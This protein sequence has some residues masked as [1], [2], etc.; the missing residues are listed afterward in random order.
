M[1]TDN[2]ANKAT[3]QSSAGIFRQSGQRST[4][5]SIGTKTL[6]ILIALS[7]IVTFP[8]ATSL[9]AEEHLSPG[10][11][12]AEQPN[13]E[14]ATGNS[15]IVQNSEIEKGSQKAATSNPADE[16]HEAKKTPRAVLPVPNE[17]GV[18]T[19]ANWADLRQAMG[20][21]SVKEIRFNNTIQR[22]GGAGSG[23]DLPAINRSLVIDAQGYT[24]DWRNDETTNGINRAGFTLN[25]PSGGSAVF[26]LKN[27]TV[28]RSIATSAHMIQASDASSEN[29]TVN[30]ENLST[31]DTPATTSGLLS[32]SRATAI[33]FS[34]GITWNSGSCNSGIVVAPIQNY[35]GAN[36]VVSITG[37]DDVIRANMNGR[38][39]VVK[40]A[41]GAD[42]FLSGLGTGTTS[43]VD[44]TANQS[45]GTKAEFIVDGESTIL[46]IQ[47]T[48]SGTGV[49]GG[50]VTMAAAPASSGGGGGF[51]VTGGATM[52]VISKRG[53]PPSTENNSG[54]PAL[55]Q[56]IDGGNF[57]VDGEGTQLNV[58]SY[59]AANNLGAT[60]RIREVG[61]QTFTLSNKAQLKVIK[62][63][64]N[65]S[66]S[67][68][69]LRFGTGENNSFFVTGGASVS[70]FNYGNKRSPATS[71]SPESKGA[72]E[73][74]AH[75]FSFQVE[76][77]QSNIN[78]I[79]TEGAAVG[80]A[81]Y[82]RG[83]ISVGKGSVFIAQGNVDSDTNGVFAAGNN[84]SFDCN[85]PLYYNFANANGRI[86]SRVFSIAG[87]DNTFSSTFSDLAVWGN[88]RARVGSGDNP[89]GNATNSS[90]NPIAGSPY[91]SWTLA[92]YSL[93]GEHF[94]TSFVSSHAL[95][96]NKVDSFGSRGM[97]PYWRIS[98][99]NAGPVI[100]ELLPATNADKYVR[101]TGTV[102]EGLDFY[103]RPFWDDEIFG[104]FNIT[105]ADGSTE[106]SGKGQTKSFEAENVYEVESVATPISS[107]LR[108]GNGS[109][110][111]TGEKY[112][113][114]S[115]WRGEVD[116]HDLSQ[117][118]SAK[119]EDIV[120]TEITVVDVLPP[121][122]ASITYPSNGRL[123]A[124]LSTQVTGTW[125]DGAHQ[126]LAQPHNPE[127]A[128][129]LYAVVNS[130][131]N[132]ISENGNPVLGT[133]NAD[134]TWSYLITEEIVNSLAEKDKVFFVLED[135]NGN[136]NPIVNTSIR[137]TTKVAAPHLAVTTSDLFLSHTDAFI[138]LNK[139]RELA[140]LGTSSS[141]QH[142]AFLELLD[143]KAEKRDPSVTMN[144]T[145]A[146]ESVSPFWD[147]AGY[148]D[149]T[150]FEAANPNGKSYAVK[151]VATEDASLNN[152]G[153]ITVLPFGHATPYIGA[154]DFTISRNFATNMMNTPT[155][156]R[157]NQLVDL[158]GA[159]GRLNTS[160]P[161]SKNN[162]VVTS[163]A[164]P[165][166][167]E[168]GI[169]DVTFQVKGAPAT[170]EYSITVKAHIVNGDDPVLMVS[171]PI[172][173]W[174]GDPAAKPSTAILPDEFDYRMGVTAFSALNG[175]NI[176]GDV[177]YDGAVNETKKGMYLVRYSVTNGDFNS[178][179]ATRVVVVNDGSYV[180]VPGT[181]ADP[182][183]ILHAQSFVK[184]RPDTHY[185]DI[186]TDSKAQA[187]IVD[188][189][190]SSGLQD[191]TA[192]VNSSGSY[193][194]ACAVGEYPI[195]IRAK[196]NPAII[197]NITAKVIEKNEI[198]DG[199][200][201]QTNARY[202]IGANDYAVSV[203]QVAEFVGTS[204][205]VALKLINAS[206]AEAW[207]LAGNITPLG[208]DLPLTSFGDSGVY[209][210]SNG[211]PA[212]GAQA[213]DTYKI[214]FAVKE[215]PSIQ[216]TVAYTI[217]GTPP[218][219]SYEPDGYPL[220]VKQSS[221]PH[222]MTDDEVKAKMTVWDAQD[223]NLLNAT[224]YV[225]DNT[226]G[227]T[228]DT[229]VVG[230]Y[231]VSY[232]VT[233][234]DGMSATA[235]RAIIVDDG[236][237][238]IDQA[239]GVIIGAKNFVI[240]KKEV[241]G[242][243]DQVRSYSRAYA[244]TIE[245]IS[246]PSSQLYI[247]NFPPNNYGA[248]CDVGTYPF[249]WMVMNKTTEK[250]IKGYV[251]DADII[252]PGG[253]NGQYAMTAR[254]FTVN[255]RE[256]QDMIDRGLNAALVS[257]ADVQVIKLV[258]SVADAVPYVVSNGG[259]SATLNT[260]P[261]YPLLFGA[262]NGSPLITSPA[263]QVATNGKVSQGSEP[264]LD[265]PT[266]LEVWIGN[267]ANKPAGAITPSEY[268]A[269]ANDQYGV[270]ALDDED[271]DITSKVTAVSDS[272]TGP[273]NLSKVGM[274]KLAYSV[275]DSDNNEVSAS[276]IVVVNDGN[277]TVGKG[278][279][280]FA[281]SFVTLLNDVTSDVSALEAEIL[282]K[283][284]VRLY[285]GSTGAQIGLTGNIAGILAGG[286][287]KAV[288]VY[289]IQITAVDVPSGT[290]TKPII[291][292]VVDAGVIGPV[293]PPLLDPTVYV[294]GNHLT[295]TISEA[296]ALAAA[297]ET[298]VLN[299][300]KTGSTKTH[301]DGTIQKLK[302]IIATD[303][304]AFLAKLTDNNDANDVGLFTMQIGD[305]ENTTFITLT[306][307]VTNGEPP[308]LTA[309][310]KPLEYLMPVGSG[311]LDA[312]GNLTRDALMAG[313]VATDADE[314]Q[315]GKPL[316]DVRSDV[317]ISILN[318]S[319]GAPGVGVSAIP[320]NQ[321]G[322]YRVTYTYVDPDRNVALDS[323]AII[324]NDGRYTYDTNFI[325]E[326]L[327]F[328]IKASE[329]DITNQDPQLLAK[330]EAAIWTVDG[331]TRT[332]V[333][334]SNGG[335]TATPGIDFG[336]VIQPYGYTALE[337]QIAAKVLSD[338]IPNA[339][340]P[341]DQNGEN[342]LARSIV[343]NN[344]RINTTDANALVAQAGTVEYEDEFLSRANVK[345][346]D[347]T[348]QT[349]AESPSATKLLVDDDGFSLA[350]NQPLKHGDSFKITH[351]CGG[352]ADAK[353]TIIAFV[354]NALPPMISAPAVRVVWTGDPAKKPADAINLADWN[355]MNS[356]YAYDDY[357]GNITDKVKLGLSQ[358]GSFVEGNPV[359]TNRLD[360]FQPISYTVTD[361]D[362]N[363]TEKTVHVIV[364]NKVALEG[365]Y[366]ILAHDFM[367]TV[368]NVSM[369]G[370]SDQTVLGLSAAKAWRIKT[371]N[372]QE[373]SSLPL[374]VNH[375][376][377][378]VDKAGYKAQAGTYKPI[379]IGIT[380]ELLYSGNP[381]SSIA[382]TVIERDEIDDVF[383]DDVRYYV[384]ANH[385]KLKLSEAS[386]F[387]GLSDSVKALLVDRAKACGWK[388]TDTTNS[389]DVDVISN[390]I[391]DASNPVIAGGKYQVTFIPK[392]VPGA[393]VSVVFEIDDG[394]SPV[395]LFEENPLVLKQS[396]SSYLLSD[397]E[398]K[399]KMKVTDLEDGDL[400]G[401]TSI[402]LP[403]GMTAIDQ[404]KIDVYSI[405]YN[406]V[407]SQGNTASATRA[408]VVDDGRFII[409]ENEEI[410]IGARDYVVQS[411][412]VTGTEL[413]AKGLSFAEAF[414]FNGKALEVS[415]SGAPQGYVL[416]AKVGTYD[417][418]WMVSGYKIKKQIKAH[419]T[420]AEVID[421][422]NKDDQHA[423]IASS[424]KVN[425]EGAQ[426][427]L[428]NAPQG[429]VDTAKAQ[430]IKLVSS[431]ADASVALKNTSGF[432]AVVA[433][434]PITFGI[435]GTSRSVDIVGTVSQGGLPDLEVI[436]PLEVWIGDVTN[437][438]AN[439][440]LP[441]EYHDLF[442]VD[443]QDDEEGDITNKVVVVSGAGTVDL[444]SVGLYNLRYSVTDQDKNTV[445]AER[446]VV[447]NDGRFDVGDGRILFAKPFVTR[448]AD[449]T[450][451]S[452]NINQEI[453]NKSL[454]T[455]FHGVSGLELNSPK[456]SV[457]NSGGYKAAIG[458]YPIT[459]VGADEPSGTLA[460][461]ITGEVVD[462]S[463][464]E[465]GPDD[466]FKDTYYL[467][468]NN[469]TIT[470]SEARDI[471]N[472]ANF[473]KALLDVLGAGGLKTC[474]DGNLQSFEPIIVDTDSFK[475]E[476]GIYK[477]ILKD[478]QNNVSMQLTVTVISGS[479]PTITAIPTP[480]EY[481]ADPQ[482]SA[483]LSRDE[484]MAGVA[485]IDEDETP[486]DISSWVVINPDSKGNE[487]LPKI[488]INEASVTKVTYFVQD[489]DGNMATVDRAII[490]ND[491]SISFNEKYILKANSFVLST[492][493][494]VGSSS[495]LILTHSK[496]KAWDSAGNP[497]NPVVND[498]GMFSLVPGD[499]YPNIGVQEDITLSKTITARVLGENTE[500]G[501]G[502]RH[503]IVADNFRIS[504]KDAQA[505]QGKKGTSEYEQIFLDRAKVASFMNT[506]SAL[507]S[508]G[509][510]RLAS[511]GGFDTAVFAQEN[512]SNYPSTFTVKFWVDE[513]K[514]AFCEIV[515]TVSNGN[516]PWIKAPALKQVNK[517]GIFTKEDYL[518][519]VTYGDVE[520]DI[521][522]LT[523][524]HNEPVDTAV[525]GSY[526]VVYTVED[527][528]GNSATAI[529][530]V[531][532]GDW[533]IDGDYAVSASS[534]VTTV[535]VAASA[536]SKDD[537]ILKLS[538]GKALGVVRDINGN[539]VDIVSV[540][541][542]VKSSAAFAAAV[543]N[544]APIKIGIAAAA[545]P[546]QSI[547][548][549][550]IDKDIIS[551]IPDGTGEIPDVNTADPN[552]DNR[553]IVAGNK[554]MLSWLDAGDLAGK[555]D[556]KTKTKLI[557]LAQAE[558]FKITGTSDISGY[559]VDV[560]EN[561]IQQQG[562][563]YS[564][565]F[566][567]KGIGGVSIKVP[568]EVLENVMPVL[569]VDGPLIFKQ[570]P[571]SVELM[572]DQL[573]D[574]VSVFDADDA[575][576]SL[577][578]VVIT[579]ANNTMPKIDTSKVGIYQVT[580]TVADKIIVDASGNPA[581]V[582]VKR[583]VIVDDGR[584]VIDSKTE[585][586]VE[587]KN[588]VVSKNHNTF[589]GSADDV[590]NRSFAKAW[591][592]SGNPLKVEL[593]GS[594]PPGFVAKDLGVYD[595]ALRAVGYGT[596]LKTIQGEVVDADVVIPGDY[597][598]KYA[599]I[600]SHFEV[601]VSEA[602]KIIDDTGLI[603]AASARVIKLLP[604]ISDAAVVVLD[605]GGFN[606][607]KGIY[608]ILFGIEGASPAKYTAKINGV[609]SDETDPIL[610]VT[611]PLELQVGDSWNRNTAMR[612]VSAFDEG[613][614]NLTDKVTYGP[615][616]GSSYFED[617]QGNL[618]EV[619]TGK[620][621]I[622]KLL[623]E[624]SDS[625]GNTA[626]APRVVVVNDGRY[627]VGSGRIL[628][629]QPFVI[630]VD[631]VETNSVELKNHL[632]AMT[633]AAA[634]DGTTGDKLPSREIELQ[635]SGNYQPTAGKYNITL[636]LK[637]T[638]TGKL[639]K[640][641][642]ALVVDAD[643]IGTKP[644]D[645]KDPSGSQV[646]IYGNNIKLRIS[647]AEK[648]LDAA[649]LE[650]AL[651][652]A[653]KAG[654]VMG[655][656][657]NG[658][659]LNQ[660][661]KITNFDDFAAVV[662]VYTITVTDA[663]GTCSIN[664]TVTVTSG[665]P[666]TITAESPVV[667]PLSSAGGLLS[668]DQKK[669]SAKASD[670]EDGDLTKEIIA[671]GLVPANV[672]GVYQVTLKVSD[673]DGNIDTKKIAVVVDDGSFIYGDDTILTA[674]SFTLDK[675]EVDMSNPDSQ[676]LLLSRAKAYKKDGTPTAV[677]VKD[678]A[679]YRDSAGQYRPWIMVSVEPGLTK[680]ITATVT[681]P[682]V[683]PAPPAPPVQ[684]PIIVNPP[685][686]NIVV[687]PPASNTYVKVDTLPAPA[688]E[689]APQAE[690]RER[691]G[692]EIVRVNVPL[693]SIEVQGSWALLNLCIAVLA[694]LLLL[695]FA[696]RFFFDRRDLRDYKEE[697]IDQEEW[698]KMTPAQR[699]ALVVRR[700][701]ERQAFCALQQ[702]NM[703]EKSFYVNAL[704]LAIVALAFIEGLIILIATQDFF[705]KMVMTDEFTVPLSLVVMVQLIV[706]MV[707][708]I[709]KNRTENNK[710]LT[711]A[712]ESN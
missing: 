10:E 501:N 570:T 358:G 655:D 71:G 137:D 320:A 29:W 397:D 204:D 365:D 400:L 684:P 652:F 511:D 403:S 562:G 67:P 547:A 543:G 78:I 292:E 580:Y 74:A 215:A 509:T 172:E 282:S 552:D 330:S 366:L 287:Q 175:S 555:L 338:G 224:K 594:L 462:A 448:L 449:V 524:T 114:V 19:V 412:K 322:I 527:T 476:K 329:V 626:E 129:K 180:V 473:N 672:A 30:I 388:V 257:R 625:D 54:M 141:Q 248:G 703:K 599:L 100:R 76:D 155:A 343:E 410:I 439:A 676:I 567:P 673:S 416:E 50:T 48:G 569:I 683:P 235:T 442:G 58:E 391:G 1:K 169:Y 585:A 94:G 630:S 33:N 422:G 436:T 519:G 237:Y 678:I 105:R 120:D 402:T 350:E 223:G 534:F 61:N 256:A 513:D 305:E 252:F 26:A 232:S 164:I 549:R 607:R 470:V 72:I 341:G 73:F 464:I 99:N 145:I 154:N 545:V 638:P 81:G 181:G 28:I 584:F 339:Q 463:V 491:G 396:A 531:L 31:A 362:Y 553:Y 696:V 704:V 328:V 447:V 7:M 351:V 679:G 184:K 614:G 326:A 532:V 461:N 239:E 16:A 176:T 162:V 383:V 478:G 394:E 101:A 49:Q 668:N 637:D 301:P 611:S 132:V 579:D 337:K 650:K 103:G 701:Q 56:Q 182:T 408:L 315:P 616:D 219:I 374:P 530:Y 456:P 22:S 11:D 189:S 174:I 316:V 143:A 18:V 309:T 68:A 550:V 87:R 647:E 627:E 481:K 592:F 560:T 44:M 691:A 126:A 643:E 636:A 667:V 440:L 231:S 656:S 311:L 46:D 606:S 98:G 271:G 600:A 333:V 17:P 540:P 615:S 372:P 695:A 413:Q 629:A 376:L 122:Q 258:D 497:G 199:E 404:N 690:P 468:G 251:S 574:G 370:T 523:L 139:A 228:I 289:P 520:D 371:I 706:P 340:K 201:P 273:V 325:I 385:V 379:V 41:E 327:S 190:L 88:G 484:I 36:T 104:R 286:Y 589:T 659:L 275:E 310:P 66:N 604:N 564:V 375:L 430:V 222:L 485:A 610:T 573:L 244:Y 195:S 398:L 670:K 658:T 324:I 241:N 206:Q 581:T 226:P 373:E 269:V 43:V 159:K 262:D 173:I 299:A 510:P 178:I 166:P 266:P 641:V 495:E 284:Q 544:Y 364:S 451:I 193:Q 382:G 321:P 52:N 229:S 500:G 535:D 265:V 142:E 612:E 621:G 620:S 488:A 639:T 135:A 217:F 140:N 13:L 507:I 6:S 675:S 608:P 152:T 319:D 42:V 515:V 466:P 345:V 578:D 489:S 107:V 421:P 254:H 263:T 694:L 700:E 27:M 702:Y 14:E 312:S 354:D 112:K 648:I 411:K 307:T 460:K 177:T 642:E 47:G 469:I 8:L 161:F 681:A 414:D 192:E 194:T 494:V 170:P 277:Y 89:A 441:G 707:A 347:R 9:F 96:T 220:S 680:Q 490:V 459:I 95:M 21:S 117:V 344:F 4:L 708:A 471:T 225:I 444:G 665:N 186:I 649:D 435:S 208:S 502:D 300:L 477:I 209:V 657:A 116:E 111:T 609:V 486:V 542:M 663:S 295:L 349:F 280:L 69:A 317:A 165:N 151:Y 561:N 291:G 710:R 288:G 214:T 522:K 261:G 187:W 125:V 281:K 559:D 651:I 705:G 230:V 377:K 147:S 63:A 227:K 591:D 185:G 335:Y 425:L 218:V 359:D 207:K 285:D 455:L 294:Y 124:G 588:F 493:D 645:P 361:S 274:Y 296:K 246:I 631:D 2:Q 445:S 233:D 697:P 331:E 197:K 671:E 160:D 243:T 136:A 546:V 503:S 563:I 183:Y 83:S 60:I 582:S 75:N 249:V 424:F 458:S 432:D 644:L 575:T 34:G 205:D 428:D 623:Y 597:D 62:H 12:M 146:V 109:F 64:S 387:I 446:V 698:R 395:I 539:I 283:A 443:A 453:L 23:N 40:V 450:T 438:P 605:D 572:K 25:A 3:C 302:T 304:D 619:D 525:E 306:I 474:A 216:V 279:I 77:Y 548:G 356:V 65:G 91:E 687:K 437:K 624:V 260:N 415:W 221:A 380:P 537:L 255:L 20:D 5:R 253:D 84:F 55:I 138:G 157:D 144:T 59:G 308:T 405:T 113:I 35:T 479:Q 565:V 556:D 628:E 418:A 130:V 598:S 264:K 353:T 278:R 198:T 602:K 465:S 357:D 368:S 90:L 210:V 399:Q 431:A 298:D 272:S 634:Y 153:A 514:T 429:F 709:L 149:K 80:A 686:N 202:T 498:P 666:P 386:S 518:A 512:E 102:P 483:T 516:H 526:K 586:I 200:D 108:Y 505:L 541:A 203:S 303:T 156:M 674:H 417:I 163:V 467:F 454:A 191:A 506:G 119:P 646:Y 238:I 79:A 389:F 15:N 131:N 551:N 593:A 529:G 617:D 150:S 45:A 293:L 427:I 346:Y 568:F 521:T 148:Y 38:H 85:E 57:V 51:R 121:V 290:I 158:A 234:S 662:G 355:G 128:V 133:L 236:R 188:S 24:L 115:A 393:K 110:L 348:H 420:D 613:D 390:Q 384:A 267:P 127:A 472:A 242:S 323:R 482:S 123:W 492:H 313:V 669:G 367:E 475:A 712:T 53:M 699:L 528:E 134:G 342:G 318:V 118:H 434:Y 688:T 211:I 538:H 259:F 212:S 682:V 496:A 583:A 97:Q 554:V 363:T 685:V 407:D 86:G 587:A 508:A 640:T 711:L 39:N 93:A 168:I 452:A 270:S 635:N 92:T 336:I 332:A 499:Y 577:A 82:Q 378:V 179:D 70:V 352:D 240:A 533:V 558:A 106:T 618:V 381:L 409:D 601:N 632:I 622:Y 419:V 401:A 423:I 426:T 406:V 576:L 480:L 590:F 487:V 213:G 692:V 689:I 595:F 245:G 247:K 360:V 196:E 517:N 334:A 566:I 660:G 536:L 603:T 32:L 596:P 167:A 171:S 276:R 571:G 457:Q 504:L 664:L 268:S 392:G 37:G 661:V 677:S 633:R 693:S 297:G 557:D 433:D 654:A 653:L 369:N 250:P 314:T